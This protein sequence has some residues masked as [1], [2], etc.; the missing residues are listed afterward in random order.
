MTSPTVDEVRTCRCHA[1]SVAQTITLRVQSHT[2][3]STPESILTQTR[4]LRVP[5]HTNKNTP[6]SSLTQTR[7]R[8]SPV[9]HKQEHARLTQ[10]IRNSHSG[11]QSSNA[12]LWVRYTV[13]GNGYGIDITGISWPTLPSRH[14]PG[15]RDDVTS[16]GN[17]DVTSA[18]RRYISSIY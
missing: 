10:H 7:T 18:G 12:S 17:D 8:Q 4:T 2:N 9:S 3:N 11:D 14:C 6:E 15:M 16:A 5:T 1:H 13:Y